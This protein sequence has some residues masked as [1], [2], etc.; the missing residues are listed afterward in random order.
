MTELAVVLQ[1]VATELE[2]MRLR[3]AVVGGLAVSVRG[4]ARFTQDAD[5]AVAA[6]S[7]VEA[8]RIAKDL[9]ARGYRILAQVEHRQTHRLAILR[10]VSP[11]SSGPNTFI[12][13]LLFASSNLEPDVVAAAQPAEVLPGMRLPVAQR[14]HLIA[15]K[16][17][18][19]SDKRGQDKIDLV[20]LIHR[21]TPADLSLA[22][23][24]L[25]SVHAHGLEQDRGLLEELAGYVE[26]AARPDTSFVTRVVKPDSPP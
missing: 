20:D 12:V 5:I 26:L 25:E 7:D 9:I 22:R 2:R 3:F 21:A 10:L 15:L 24:A 8:E 13:D 1:D 11:R 17:I 14:G 4:T 6:S 19:A 18:S 16:V 23:S